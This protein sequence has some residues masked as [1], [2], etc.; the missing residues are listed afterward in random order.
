LLTLGGAGGGTVG[1]ADASPVLGGVVGAGAGASV[2]AGV[3]GGGG[4]ASLWAG[5]G[6]GAAG[7]LGWG[8]LVAA[9]G[10]AVVSVVTCVT[11]AAAGLTATGLTGGETLATGR[12]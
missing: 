3:G 12:E 1:V 9:V 6:A 8:W 2:A 4:G 11:G 5:A 10:S 7:V